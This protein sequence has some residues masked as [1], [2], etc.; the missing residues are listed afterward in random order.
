MRVT[1]ICRYNDDII[2]ISLLWRIPEFVPTP[3]NMKYAPLG[4]NVILVCPFL[5]NNKNPLIRIIINIIYQF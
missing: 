1:Q 5:K 3:T 2:N 4:A